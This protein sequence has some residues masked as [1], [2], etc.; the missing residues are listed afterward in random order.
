MAKKYGYDDFLAVLDYLQDQGNVFVSGIN[1]RSADP[2]SY[3][4]IVDPKSLINTIHSSDIP[5][6]LWLATAN[7]FETA[8]NWSPTVKITALLIK[9]V[10]S[11]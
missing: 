7:F 11:R 6:D 2:N 1:G 9:G 3:M 10:V 4:T 5:D 8:P